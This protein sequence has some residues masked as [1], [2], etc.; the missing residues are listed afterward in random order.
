MY[1]TVLFVC[2]Y[3]CYVCAWYTWRSEQASRSLEL[4]LRMVVIHHVGAGN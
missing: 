3:A 2:M 4:K 1:L